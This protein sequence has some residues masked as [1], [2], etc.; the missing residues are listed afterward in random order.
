MGYK[1]PFE[2]PDEKLWDKKIKDFKIP[3]RNESLEKKVAEIKGYIYVPTI[4]LYVSKGRFLYDLNWYGAH[5]ELHRQ[6]LQMLTPRQFIDFILYLK[7]NKSSIPDAKKI[8]DGLL[9]RKGRYRGEWLDAKFSEGEGRLCIS[10]NHRV[11][12]GKLIAQN[13]E[14]L[15]KCLMEDEDRKIDLKSCNKQGLPT[16]EGNDITYQC[17]VEGCVARFF[18]AYGDGLY[19]DGLDCTA[20]ADYPDLSI[21]VRAARKK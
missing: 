3:E 21:G 8:L 18:Q 6:G 10:Y 11:I 14:P 16:K 12:K 13:K 1:N 20:Y 17:P 9:I 4:G 19:G 7:Q 15:E 2:D 5:R